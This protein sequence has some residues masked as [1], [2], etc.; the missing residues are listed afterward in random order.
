MFL[1][2][3]A[4]EGSANPGFV[5]QAIRNTSSAIV[6]SV[7]HEIEIW[8][9]AVLMLSRYAG[10]AE[11]NSFGHAMEL[12]AKGESRRSA[13]KLAAEGDQRWGGYLASDHSRDRAPYRHGGPLN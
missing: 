5:V 10:D 2:I 6:P 3:R 13:P 11:A 12:R 1:K 8:R 4:K 7:I 9:A